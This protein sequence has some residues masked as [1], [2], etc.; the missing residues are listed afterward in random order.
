MT[1]LAFVGGFVLGV[2]VAL[3]VAAVGQALERPGNGGAR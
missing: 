3:H 1:A 2:V